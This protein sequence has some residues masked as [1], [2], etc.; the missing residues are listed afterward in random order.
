MTLA[1]NLN[2]EILFQFPGFLSAILCS[3]VDITISEEDIFKTEL[4][5]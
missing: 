1:L 5:L 3:L 2:Y 4:L